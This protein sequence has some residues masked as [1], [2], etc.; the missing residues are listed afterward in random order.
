ME[1]TDIVKQ[2]VGLQNIGLKGARVGLTHSLRAFNASHMRGLL[3]LKTLA[4]VRYSM[5]VYSSLF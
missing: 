2:K 3:T 1:S 4:S 5:W